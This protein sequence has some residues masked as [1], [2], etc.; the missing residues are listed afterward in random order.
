M[1]DFEMTFD[2][3]FFSRCICTRKPSL[4]QR[5]VKRATEAH[6]SAVGSWLYRLGEAWNEW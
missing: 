4:W 6:N 2:D 3:K 5:I 1:H